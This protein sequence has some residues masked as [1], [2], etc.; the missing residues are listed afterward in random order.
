MKKIDDY[1]YYSKR[2]TYDTIYYRKNGLKGEEEIILDGDREL[3]S[4]NG[5]VMI[6]AVKVSLNHRYLAFSRVRDSFNNVSDVEI[7]DLDNRIIVGTIE[8]VLS[9][10]WGN[11]NESIYFIESK[12]DSDYLVLKKWILG[13]SSYIDIYKKDKNDHY[14]TVYNTSDGQQIF[15]TDQTDKD[16]STILVFPN[17]ETLQIYKTPKIDDFIL[18]RSNGKF[19]AI[20]KD[21]KTLLSSVKMFDI[22]N[23]L[24]Y[25]QW[26]EVIP[27][28]DNASIM[29]METFS[30]CIL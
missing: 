4:Y 27:H 28:I 30:V 5:K 16:V 20:V 8:N 6:K 22:T 14:L 1:Y 19:C 12:K 17:N 15:I 26:E 10:E 24:R 11:D 29:D 23:A 7:R 13:E 3:Q 21:S 18:N 2:G 9:F 25:D